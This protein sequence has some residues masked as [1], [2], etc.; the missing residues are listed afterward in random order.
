VTGLHDSWQEYSTRR[1]VHRKADK[2]QDSRQKYRTA[3]RSEG[4]RAG[5]QTTRPLTETGQLTEGKYS[6]EDQENGMK[7]SINELGKVL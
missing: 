2:L 6:S 7:S 1:R 3:D 5:L 4:Q